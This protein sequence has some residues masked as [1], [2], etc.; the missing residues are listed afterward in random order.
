M[1][2]L[3]MWTDTHVFIHQHRVSSNADTNHFD[4]HQCITP[5]TQSAAG[6]W[7]RD[8]ML[9]T[10]RTGAEHWSNISYTMHTPV[11][12]HERSASPTFCSFSS[13]SWPP[14]SSP[15]ST[16]MLS[17][18][19]SFHAGSYILSAWATKAALSLGCA[20]AGTLS[21]KAQSWLCVQVVGHQLVV[22]VERGYLR[23]LL[24][25]RSEVARHLARLL[26]LDFSSSGNRKMRILRRV[27]CS[28]ANSAAAR[29][30]HWE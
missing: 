15:S 14:A 30:T 20:S 24:V 2:F 29:R 11:F 6:S 8:I 3:K 23:E 7:S 16:L 1:T 13:S 26:V 19:G 28:S 22:E 21:A 18:T 12:V 25:A 9:N 17:P 5:S 27:T 10:A 4:H